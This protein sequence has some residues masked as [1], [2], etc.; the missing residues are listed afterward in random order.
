MDG[1][2]NC[3]K[4]MLVDRG[5][6][7]RWMSDKVSKVLATVRK[8]CT[9]TAQVTLETMKKIVQVI[10]CNLDD[11]VRFLAPPKDYSV[12]ETTSKK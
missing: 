4:V 7:N 9:N 2:I 3:I 6:T 8:W 11:H 1:E 5:H 10:V 12:R